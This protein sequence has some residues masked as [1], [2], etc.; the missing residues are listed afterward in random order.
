MGLW[1]R[2]CEF[3]STAAVIAGPP[4][5]C[6]ATFA[7]LLRFP[8]G[9]RKGVTLGRYTLLAYLLWMFLIDRNTPKLG[10]R[11][12]PGMRSSFLWRQ[13]RRYFSAHVVKDAGDPDPRGR[14]VI[15][16]HPHGIV[17]IATFC[18]LLGNPGTVFPNLDY[19]VL[20]V[21]ANFNIPFWREILMGM[22]FVDAERGSVRHLLDAGTSVGV[23][24]GGAAESLDARPSVNELTLNR[25]LGFVRLAL[26]H[27]AELIPVFTFGETD[28]FRQAVGNPR[29]SL[30][31]RLQDAA[32]H[33]LGFTVPLV[34]GRGAGLG[35]VPFRRRLLTVIGAPLSVGFNPNPTLEEIQAAHAKYLEALTSLYNRYRPLAHA[36]DVPAPPLL[37]TDPPPRAVELDRIREQLERRRLHAE[38]L[39]H[40]QGVDVTD[41][42]FRWRQYGLPDQFAEAQGARQAVRWEDEAE[43]AVAQVAA[44]EA[45]AEAAATAEAEADAARAADE[46]TQAGPAGAVGSARTRVWPEGA[47]AARRV[48]AEHG[49]TGVVTAAEIARA[50]A[51]AA[52]AE[53]LIGAVS[54]GAAE[55]PVAP[56][57]ALF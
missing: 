37:I 40:G 56:I 19:R 8:F 30:V 3:Y 33:V 39:A 44:Q 17:S 51:D 31:R 43:L 20:T 16:I 28:T 13:M 29:G 38:R 6:V 26:E 50:E 55:S 35:V 27:G 45:A 32:T 34:H 54:T 24:V 57:V 2:F 10:G 52:E 25:R 7:A 46:A 15:G 49:A 23:V 21:S 47:D 12:R 42:R 14:Y 11:L 41:P 36:L 18:N 9:G 4:L 48:I 5:V 53:R 1:S 22:G